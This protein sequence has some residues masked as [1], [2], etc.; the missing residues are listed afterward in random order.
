MDALFIAGFALDVGGSFTACRGVADTARRLARL[1][2]ATGA[3]DTVLDPVSLVL[4]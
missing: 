3:V 2:L 4:E 1:D